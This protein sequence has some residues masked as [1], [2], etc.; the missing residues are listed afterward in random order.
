MHVTTGTFATANGPKYLQQMCKHFAHERSV[1]YTE[2]E[3]SVRFP[4]GTA[5]LTA[6]DAGIT[7]RFELENDDAFEAAQHVIDSHLERFAF[8]E[9][10][11]G[12][13]WDWAPPPSPR[14]MIH[15]AKTLL[16]ARAPGLVDLLRKA[17]SRLS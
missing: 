7:V 16:K 3:G 14:S 1:E 13:D 11:T 15:A 2:T 9:S 8:R 17:K 6:D 5:H 4:M 12:M 10:F